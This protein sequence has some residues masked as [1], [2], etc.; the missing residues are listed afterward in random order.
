MVEGAGPG[1]GRAHMGPAVT[2]CMS[3]KFPHYCQ[4]HDPG[5]SGDTDGGPRLKRRS[6]HI[7]L[8]GDPISIPGS[9]TLMVSPGQE[10]AQ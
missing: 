8:S 2:S 3:E 1:Q 5:M 10:E 9:V 4:V 7:T 6:D